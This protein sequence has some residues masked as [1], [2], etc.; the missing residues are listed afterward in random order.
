MASTYSITFSDD[1]DLGEPGDRF[2]SRVEAEARLAQLQASGRYT[3]LLQWQNDQSLEVKR[4]N[5]PL[6]SR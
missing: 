3:R 6:G 4:V 5:A 2:K 1:D